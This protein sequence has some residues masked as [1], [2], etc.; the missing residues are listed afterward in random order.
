MA[1]LQNITIYRGDDVTFQI[2]F[3]DNSGTAVDITGATLYFTAKTNNDDADGSAV[4]QSSN[5]T[6]SDPSNGIGEAVLSN[7][8]TDV[9]PGK[10]F[11]DIQIITAGGEITTAM[12]GK[13]TVKQ[14]ITLAEA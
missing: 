9:T 8:D 10:Y 2:T 1:T 5:S 6:L 14:D 7:S 4:I 11:Y 3:K 13:V 12:I